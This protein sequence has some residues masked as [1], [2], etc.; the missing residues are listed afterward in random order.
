MA[1]CRDLL[2]IDT[3]AVHVASAM[4]VPVL[5][6]FPEEGA[7]HTVPRWRPWMTPHRVVLKPE[8]TQ[9]AFDGFL[10]QLRGTMSELDEILLGP[11]A[12]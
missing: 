5:D 11:V 8:F 6:V 3:G 10:D 1:E 2:S 4:G 7:H 12:I 9:D